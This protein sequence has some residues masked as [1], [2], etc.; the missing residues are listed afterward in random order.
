MALRVFP[1][2]LSLIGPDIDFLKSNKVLEKNN[3]MH[4]KSRAPPPKK[5]WQKG[6]LYHLWWSYPFLHMHA[7]RFVHSLFAA[8]FETFFVNFKNSL[9]TVLTRNVTHSLHNRFHGFFRAD[10]LRI[11]QPV[12]SKSCKLSLNK[13]YVVPIRLYS[14]NLF[15]NCDAVHV[16][17]SCYAPVSASV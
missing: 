3:W 7:K 13:T 11:L 5:K 1:E 8:W 2:N 4:C 17:M 6:M 14:I 16:Q 15:S 9:G 12:H 10:R